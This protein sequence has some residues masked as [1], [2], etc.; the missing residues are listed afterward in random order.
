M[1][2][3]MET[4]IM[5]PPEKVPR[6]FGKLPNSLSVFYLSASGPWWSSLTEITCK[7]LDTAPTH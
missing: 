2:K 4:T 5:S 3:K 1:E 7:T 6:F